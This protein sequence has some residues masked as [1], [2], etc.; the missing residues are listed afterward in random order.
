MPTFPN[1]PEQCVPNKLDSHFV[2]LDPECQDEWVKYGIV[3]HWNGTEFVGGKGDVT[4]VLRWT[5]GTC[6]LPGFEIAWE[7]AGCDEGLTVGFFTT[8][9]PFSVW[10]EDYIDGSCC[11][12]HTHVHLLST[13]A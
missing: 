5:G 9:S 11:A 3:A 4:L 8:W 10:G 6:D 7:A 2:P 13:F 12:P 1:C